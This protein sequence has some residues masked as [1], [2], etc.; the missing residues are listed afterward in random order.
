M[1]VAQ[2]CG[3]RRNTVRADGRVD[4][5]QVRLRLP[6]RFPAVAEPN[7]EAMVL[8][9]APNWALS[10]S[11]LLFSL[12]ILSSNS[13]HA[14]GMEL[15]AIGVEVIGGTLLTGGR[16][17]VVGSLLGVLVLAFVVVQRFATRRPS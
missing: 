3:G 12:Y 14:I 9:T 11:G 15:D 8:G 10:S 4:R 1:A 5:D 2:D 6:A 17:Y 13:L 7:V 16:A